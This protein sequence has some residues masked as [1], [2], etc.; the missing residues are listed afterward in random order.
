MSSA[1]RIR[2]GARSSLKDKKK[3]TLAD[4]F[5]L[6]GGAPSSASSSVT[7]VTTSKFRTLTSPV[8]VFSALETLVWSCY[9]FNVSF[10]Q[11]TP[12]ITCSLAVVLGPFDN[13]SGIEQ[14]GSV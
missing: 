11:L 9:L 4:E 10:A 8:A 2:A 7:T 5:K 12:N 3:L 6:P 13:D 1:R 14:T